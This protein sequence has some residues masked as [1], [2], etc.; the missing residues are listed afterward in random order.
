[1]ILFLM[2][3]KYKI[4]CS[5]QDEGEK[6][7]LQQFSSCNEIQRSVESTFSIHVLLIL[8]LPRYIYG[9]GIYRAITFFPFVESKEAN[10]LN[11]PFLFLSLFCPL[12]SS[13]I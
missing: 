13:V 12:S 10:P 7:I 8:S 3:I 1:M 5:D 9:I 6:V 2:H 11:S 4:H